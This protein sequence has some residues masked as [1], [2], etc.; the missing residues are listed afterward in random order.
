MYKSVSSTIIGGV[1]ALQYS[2][3]LNIGISGTVVL[4]SDSN[5]DGVDGQNES[6]LA[7]SRLNQ[8][9]IDLSSVINSRDTEIDRLVNE[10]ELFV[11]KVCKHRFVDIVIKPCYHTTCSRCME[12]FVNSYI[13]DSR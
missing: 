2:E 10:L 6:G 9:I 3:S 5:V 8:Q 4:E 12:V 13:I 7:I 11:C 1:S